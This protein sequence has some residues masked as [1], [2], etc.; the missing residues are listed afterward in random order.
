MIATSL[1][2]CVDSTCIEVYVSGPPIAE[3]VM[4]TTMGCAILPVTFTNMSIGYQ[5]V[6][7]F[8]D[9]EGGDPPTST[10][11]QP[12]TVLFDQGTTDTTYFITLTAEN[13]CG[14]DSFT[15]SII[16][17][18]KP[19]TDFAASQYSGCTP[20]PVAFNNIT[21]GEPDSFLWD[22]G[23]G[24]IYM[25]SIPPDQLYTAVGPDNEIYNVT[26]IA[27][28][29]CGSDTLTQQIL[30][31]PDSIR[32]FFSVDVNDGCEPLTVNFDNSTAP[33]SAIVYNWFFDQN[34]DTSNAVD[35]SY[36][37][38]ATG[39]TIT[40]YTVSLVADNGCARDTF[41]LDITVKPAPDVSFEVPP[42]V[43]AEDSV[44][45][46]NTSIDVSGPIWEFGDGDTSL[47]NNPIHLYD[48]PGEYTVTLT[49]FANN[50]GCPN[51]DSTVILV[52]E[53]PEPALDASPTAGCPPLVVTLVN[54]SQDGVFF[55]WDFGD[56]NTDVGPNPGSH[57]YRESGFY[58]ITLT[59]IDSFGCAGDT[60]F[61]FIQV[62]PVP[63][64]DFE[65]EMLDSCGLPQ[66]VCMI[67]FSE[68][69]LGFD[70]LV[71]GIPSTDNSPCFIFDEAGTYDVSLLVENEFT[72]T[73]MATGQFTVYDE[74]L[75]LFEGD[76]VSCLG[77]L[78]IFN[79]LS[80]NAD[81]VFWDY[82]DGTT[83]TTWHGTHIY[84]DTGAYQVT[85]IVGNGSG[86]M[87]TFSLTELVRVYLS[88]TADFTFEKLDDELG[89]TY[90][91]ID[92]SSE[93]A[94]NFFW[95][96]GDDST[97]TTPDVIH[98]YISSRPK[99]ITHIVSN[100]YGCADT[101]IA[102]LE[103]DLLTGLFI[104]NILEPNNNEEFENTIFLPKGI[105]LE[106]YHIAVYARNGQLVWESIELD[107]FD[108]GIPVGFWDGTFDGEE[109]P[110]GV[111]VWKVHK[112]KFR[113]GLIWEGMKDESGKYRTSNYLYLV[114]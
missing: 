33:D 4:D 46:F 81:Y 5:Y 37:F 75:A 80:E 104:P 102:L 88:P 6:N 74:P 70:W 10:I 28:N 92:Q 19:L 61:S 2:G 89:N 18:P 9:F 11:E 53:L 52:R 39:D 35:T 98:R 95:D 7:Y 43:C 30:V 66:E 99:T 68:G 23:N 114:R 85:L 103:L 108:E 78:M 96:M 22:M 17:F 27:F 71:D 82:G 91:F 106:E 48:E 31:K 58:D 93:D 44:Q 36:T 24:N 84:A 111:Y 12:G 14:V 79:N 86:C 109:L 16:V 65:V 56:G 20:L 55:T 87:D 49:V 8:W 62:Y 90:E 107:P 1:E 26:L 41:S 105:G 64:A 57:I 59:A 38:Y 67:N 32:A 72:C 45:F 60:V 113:N 13:H 25:D 83:D 47:A 101:A 50:T 97:Y 42:V 76:T 63:I 21:L 54:E 15:D 94:I 40:T 34:D 100:M 3:F 73:D 29:E 112:A 110:G 51:T 69:A 77:E